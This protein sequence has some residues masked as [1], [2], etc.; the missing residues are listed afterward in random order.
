[1]VSSPRVVDVLVKLLLSG[2]RDPTPKIWIEIAS[3]WVGV[4]GQ[5]GACEIL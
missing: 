5:E 1:M 2:S 4:L 3:T